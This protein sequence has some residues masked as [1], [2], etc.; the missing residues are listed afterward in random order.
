MISARDLEYSCHFPYW[1]TC[2]AIVR[3]ETQKHR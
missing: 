1:L 2:D 3:A